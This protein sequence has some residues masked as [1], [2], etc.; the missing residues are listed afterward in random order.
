MYAKHEIRLD[1]IWKMFA[2][3]EVENLNNDRNII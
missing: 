1:V 3:W 2:Y